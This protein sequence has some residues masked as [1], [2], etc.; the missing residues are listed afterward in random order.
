MTVAAASRP[1]SSRRKAAVAL[2]ALGE[3][4]ATAVLRG[5]DRATVRELVAEI[6]RLG[7]VR[8]DEVRTALDELSASLGSDAHLP[9]PSPKFAENLLRGALGDVEA[10]AAAEL[11]APAPFSWLAES[12]HA[13]ATAILSTQPPSVVAVA[14]AHLPPQ[15]AAPLL[16]SLAPEVAAGVAVRLAGLRA[17][18]PSAVHEV[19][20]SLRQEFVAATIDA[21]QHVPGPVVLADIL[22]HAGGDSR[23]A[24]LATLAAADPELAEQV[25]AALFT[26]NDLA[27]LSPRTLQQIVAACDS[28]DLAKA[29]WQAAPGV[30]EIVLANMSERARESLLEEQELFATQPVPAA[31]VSAARREVVAVARRLE[32]EGAIQLTR[33][34]G[35]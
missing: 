14:L 2:V 5:L 11:H 1:G 24:M 16:R 17:L 28:R 27:D 9:A 8:A 22:A 12:D 26:F 31:E 15:Q 3:E 18:H 7:P 34:G 33:D 21:A 29:L 23:G 10:D 32:D 35:A 4:R 19:E 25:R 20:A 13:L 6:A 30:V